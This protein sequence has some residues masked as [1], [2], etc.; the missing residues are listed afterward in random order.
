MGTRAGR[1][2]LTSEI[3][4]PEPEHRELPSLYIEDDVL[5]PRR[6]LPEPLKPLLALVHTLNDWWRDLVVMSL[7][8][9]AWTILSATVIAG[10]PAWAAL[11]AMSRASAL[12]E[13]P[14]IPLFIAAMRS[15][16]FKS[17]LLAGVSILAAAIWAA[18]LNFYLKFVQNIEALAWLG[19]VLF[20]Y[21]GLVMLQ[22]LFYAWPLLVCRD[23]LSVR[24]L[25]RE[26]V[27]LALRYPL[28]NAI[29]TLFIAL[30]VLISIYLPPLIVLVLPAMISLLGF[31]N[32]YA[33][34]TDLVEDDNLAYNVVN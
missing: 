24:Q 11:Y 33:L 3:L 6:E 2:D 4:E 14:D 28:R 7:A 8:S 9:L 20:L 17:W 16:F 1:A 21:I 30:M 5:P 34:D 26:G 10:P 18:D 29:S 32:L 25:L 12:H 31:H 13:H 15:Y 22:T 27:L 23:D 19:S